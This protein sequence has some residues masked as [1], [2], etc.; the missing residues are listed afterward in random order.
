MSSANRDLIQRLVDGFNSRDRATLED[1]Y[2]P[3]CSGSTADGPLLGRGEHLA[4]FEKYW[5]SFPDGCFYVNFL[6]ADGEFVALHYT[7]AGTNTHSL[8]GS[9]ATGRRMSV[10]S[11][12]F[13]R[14]KDSRIF[15]QYFIWDN[16]GPRR[17]E[18]LASTIEKQFLGTQPV[19]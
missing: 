18:W 13:S 14:I 7:F 9:P 3:D 8:V 12:L 11:A 15:E 17:Q 1:L 16:L 2:A 6:A 5:L 10:P 4:F 19:P